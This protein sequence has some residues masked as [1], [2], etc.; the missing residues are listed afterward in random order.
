[1]RQIKTKQRE[2]KAR[3]N[4]VGEKFKLENLSDKQNAKKIW[5][6]RNFKK[7]LRGKLNFKALMF[8]AEPSRFHL[9]FASFVVHE[10]NRKVKVNRQWRLI[11]FTRKLSHNQII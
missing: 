7:D 3:R 1:M 8:Q 4:S 6:L 11:A 9:L 2:L 10:V 5:K